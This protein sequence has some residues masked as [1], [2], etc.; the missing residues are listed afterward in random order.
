MNL[1]KL[2]IATRGKAF[3]ML[4]K[5]VKQTQSRRYLAQYTADLKM[6][7]QENDRNREE[8]AYS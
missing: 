1:H 6:L 2:F 3:F 4:K 7:D 5:A 8:L